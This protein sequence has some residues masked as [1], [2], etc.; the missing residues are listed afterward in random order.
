MRE[1]C[2]EGV[3][4][5]ERIL[6]NRYLLK[7]RIGIGGM[8]S[9]YTAEDTTLDRLVAVKIMLPQYASDPSFA[10]RFRQE[11]TAAAAL[12]S[13]R[14]VSIHD[15]GCDDEDYFIVMELL[16]GSDMRAI[17]RNE[18]PLDS[19]RIRDIGDQVCQA[20]SVA[21]AR[22]IIHR[23]ITP[24]NIMVLPDGNVKVMDFGIAKVAGSSMT[25]TSTVLGTAHYL[26]PEQA[27]G[28]AL[29]FASDLYSLGAVLY[30]AAAGRPVFDGPDPISVALQHV[31]ADPIPLRAVNPSVDGALEAIIMKALAKDPAKR[32]QSAE[33][34][35]RALAGDPNA[36]GQTAILGTDQTAH[37][38]STQVLPRQTATLPNT[39]LVMP[40]SSSDKV[41]KV[42]TDA[43]P[44]QPKK[45]RRWPAVVAILAMGL[46][47]SAVAVLTIKPWEPASLANTG[48]ASAET[49]NDNT[50]AQA[51]PQEEPSADEEVLPEEEAESS[52]PTDTETATQSPQ[53]PPSLED[54]QIF[55]ALEAAYNEI[56][57]WDGTIK[58]AAEEFNAHYLDDTAQREEYSQC[59]SSTS[60]AVRKQSEELSGLGNEISL[61]FPWYNFYLDVRE[62]YECLEFRINA[63]VEAWNISLSY[64]SPSEHQSEIL[65]P[66]NR[67]KDETGGNRYLNRFQEIY[68]LVKPPALASDNATESHV[69]NAFVSFEIPEAWAG[70][71]VVVYN[72][73]TVIVRSKEDI[74][75]VGALCTAEVIDEELEES[76]GDIGNSMYYSPR[77][78][79]GQKIR[80]NVPNYPFLAL[81]Q[82]HS[83][84]PS[85]T[86]LP[87][88]LL[89]TYVKLQT[90]GEQNLKTIAN[91]P[92]ESAV[93]TYA[94]DYFEKTVMPTVQMR[95]I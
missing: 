53:N 70:K 48:G 67:N 72:G 77:N 1:Y 81:A 89:D 11:A 88:D 40:S 57:R 93:G 66:I 61:D 80:F 21:H 4:M 87:D 63:I 16:T 39:T 45:K 38:E 23:D 26:S 95:Q 51:A 43:I 55:L 47:L 25:Q 75:G 56:D 83:G 82:I 71:V 58:Q 20:L 29:T 62:L 5:A 68:P 30:E 86:N 90:N 7:E 8:A 27:Q 24:Q 73:S 3:S 91:M 41:L 59:A 2:A 10:Q 84:D 34:M 28:R 36:D 92:D 46:I 37:S 54:Y 33:A 22:K 13:P 14:I 65:E 64:N 79:H 31:S 19:R 6:G 15:W 9:V 42:D 52:A 44:K 49:Q 74:S 18:T 60:E 35:R 78:G 32:F 17:M 50:P 69:E 76:Q 12:Q 85:T 94:F